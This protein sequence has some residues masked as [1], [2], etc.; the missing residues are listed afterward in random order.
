MTEAHHLECCLLG[1]KLEERGFAV[2]GMND[3]PYLYE[4]AQQTQVA[5]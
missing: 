1:H 5:T 2:S 3:E 4:F